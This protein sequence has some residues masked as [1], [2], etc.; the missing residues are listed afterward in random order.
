MIS[1]SHHQSWAWDL[2]WKADRLQSCVPQ[3]STGSGDAAVALDAAWMAWFASLP[4][5]TRLLD[6]GT[7]NG[8]LAALAVKSARERKVDFTIDAV[9]A[10][11]ID[12]VQ[13][14]KTGGEALQNVRFHPR[15]LM[16][17]LPFDDGTFTA[18]SGQYALEYAPIDE[19][20]P[21]IL[22]V[23][24]PRGAFRFLIHAKDSVLM[25][26]SSQQMAQL[27][28]I[29]DS[30]L[31]ALMR[32]Q[33][34]AIK[35]MEQR[36]QHIRASGTLNAHD[37][38]ALEAKAREASQSL[39]IA[40]ARLVRDGTA[41]GAG[42]IFK[43]FMESAGWLFEQRHKLDDAAIKALIDEIDLKRAARHQRLS[44]LLAA[45]HDE[46]QGRALHDLFARYGRHRHG[47]GRVAI[48]PAIFGTQQIKLGWWL[49]GNRS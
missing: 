19:A 20:V 11:D 23:L 47:G 43:A 39:A 14:V 34:P 44:A 36:V 42:D 32:E 22:R 1:N 29:E 13:Y 9:D 45:A 31:I 15:T 24:A 21:E 35:D 7:G 40:V 6:V 16:Q 38:H 3:N 26:H 12:P 30:G 48:S 10:A 28:M 37:S 18:I 5:Q 41:L 33:I 27:Q 25:T 46:D 2:Y 17:K 4:N 8:A 49:T